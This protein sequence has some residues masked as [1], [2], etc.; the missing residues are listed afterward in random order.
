[1][2]KTPEGIEV[3]EGPSQDGGG[4]IRSGTDVTYVAELSNTQFKSRNSSYMTT[5][6][7][8]HKRNCLQLNDFV[9]RNR[10]TSV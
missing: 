1:M 7:T 2:S 3:I 5:L 9:F 8:L 10:G 4:D 6:I